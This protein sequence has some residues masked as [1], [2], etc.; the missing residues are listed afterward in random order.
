MWVSWKH[1]HTDFSQPTT[2]EN[3]VAIFHEKVWGW[4][5]HI[6]ELCLDGGK[7]HDGS[8]DLPK[9]PHS[10]FA[11]LQIMLSYFEMIAKYEN[12]FIP[13]NPKQGE[14]AKYFKLG[15]KSVFPRLVNQNQDEVNSFLETFYEKG[16]C[17]L[18]HIAQTET[19]ILL[20]GELPEAMRFDTTSKTLIINPHR[21]PVVLKSHLGDYRVR[22]LDTN[23]ADLRQKFE[24]RYNYDNP[25]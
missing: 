10:A 14:S 4:Q 23:N 2:F 19:G 21:L 7:A 13:V 3:K 22:L 6:A 11:A 8:T 1:Q 16:R 18:Y 15:V 24:S 25:V 9:I 20:T 12:G 5:L 17:G